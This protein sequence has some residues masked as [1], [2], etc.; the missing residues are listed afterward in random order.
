MALIECKECNGKVSEQADVCPCYGVKDP[1]IPFELERLYR[2]LDSLRAEET[3]QAELYQ[4]FYDQIENGVFGVLF[5]RL[6]FCIK[7]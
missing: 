1:S 7:N 5:R 2:Q 3:R 4:K 6:L